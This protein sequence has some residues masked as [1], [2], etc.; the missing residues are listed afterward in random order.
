LKPLVS[1]GVVFVMLSEHSRAPTEGESSEKKRRTH[2][3]THARGS[4]W[5]KFPR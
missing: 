5:V 2:K 1:T 4:K 3:S